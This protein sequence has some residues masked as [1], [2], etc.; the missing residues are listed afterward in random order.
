MRILLIFRTFRVSFILRSFTETCCHVRLWRRLV[1][2]RVGYELKSIKTQYLLA[3][4]ASSNHMVECLRLNQATLQGSRSL[5]LLF[6]EIAL[7]QKAAPQAKNEIKMILNGDSGV[8][9]SGASP[10]K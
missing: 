7:I 6:R 9:G 1:A 3:Q 10:S 2:F 5:L 8:D 4:E